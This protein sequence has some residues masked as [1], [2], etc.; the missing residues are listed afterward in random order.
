M[1]CVSMMPMSSGMA[2]APAEMKSSMISRNG[3]MS[4]RILVIMAINGPSDLVA[5]KKERNRNM[6]KMM[7]RPAMFNAMASSSFRSM[8]SALKKKTIRI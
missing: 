8:V 2:M 6:T 5:R 4:R 3:A 7:A 1:V